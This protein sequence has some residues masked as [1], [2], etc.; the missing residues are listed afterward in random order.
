VPLAWVLRR[1]GVPA[2]V[3]AASCLLLALALEVAQLFVAG[4]TFDVTEGLL[5]ALAVPLTARLDPEC[6]PAR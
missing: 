3:A 4:R 1:R 5:A 2:M 6:R